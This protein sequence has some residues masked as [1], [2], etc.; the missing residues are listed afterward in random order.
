MNSKKN[1]FLPF[2]LTLAISLS[3]CFIVDT[4]HAAKDKIV[5]GTKTVLAQAK[6]ISKIKQAE[7]S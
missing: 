3:G 4:A 1:L 5:R 6:A 2:I 7:I